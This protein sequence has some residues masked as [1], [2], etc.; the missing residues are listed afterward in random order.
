[1][2][3]EFKSLHLNRLISIDVSRIYTSISE[4][5]NSYMVCSLTSEDVWE[6]SKE[7]YEI[8]RSAIHN[9]EGLEW[10][11]LNFRAQGR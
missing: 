5:K 9:I 8:I 7:Q 1:M 6:V 4:E 10:D 11:A 3:I 2:R